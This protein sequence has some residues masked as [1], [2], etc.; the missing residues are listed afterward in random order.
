MQKSFGFFLVFIFLLSFS[1]ALVFLFRNNAQ[2]PG[3]G[4]FNDIF[5]PVRRSVVGMVTK[6]EK[7]SSLQQENDKLRKELLDQQ[8]SMADLKAL[9]DQFET[10]KI[11]SNTLL[12]AAIVGMKG[13][14]PGVSLPEGLILARG[15][16][17][18]VRVG[19]VVVYQ[20]NVIGKIGKTTETTALVN[21]LYSENSTINAK[22]LHTNAI[23][24]IRGLGQGVMSMEG[25][26]LSE[27]LEKGDEVLTKGDEDLDKTGYPPD[28]VIGKIVS[29]DKK[30]SNLFQTAQVE[31]LVPITKLTTV[32]IMTQ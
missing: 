24:L 12:P 6:D 19:Q 3:G 30:A 31:S 15:S 11:R 8:K 18:G 9:R 7:E 32:F 21:L 20:D 16:Q 2:V 26:V 28:L 14:V 23:G 29:V 1:S 5:S 22:T 13:F 10:Q 4:V 25:V 17:D 27:K